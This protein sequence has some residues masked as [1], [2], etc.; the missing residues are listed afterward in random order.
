MSW[1]DIETWVVAIESCVVVIS[2]VRVVTVVIN[3]GAEKEAVIIL[4]DVGAATTCVF[5]CD[6]GLSLFDGVA[7]LS[8]GS[9]VAASHAHAYGEFVVAVGVALDLIC[10][11]RR[12]S[13]I[14]PVFDLTIG[15]RAGILESLAHICVCH[16]RSLFKI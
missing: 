2:I 7:I 15:Y 4:K 8:E 13:E 1:A 9:D 5:V 11:G 3:I 12:I 14:V 10:D 16:S 6:V